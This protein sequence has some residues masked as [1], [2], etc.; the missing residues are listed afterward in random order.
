MISTEKSYIQPKLIAL[1]VDSIKQSLTLNT[2][3]NI[4]TPIDD[5]GHIYSTVSGIIKQFIVQKDE[6]NTI[7]DYVIIEND[8][9]NTV[10]P[11]I[12]KMTTKH[13]IE[14]YFSP[15]LSIEQLGSLH[16]TYLIVD[17]VFFDEPFATLDQ[18][19]IENSYD[20]IMT[21]L[22]SLHDIYVFK[23]VILLVKDDVS[24]RFLNSQ[25]FPIEVKSIKPEK[26]ID[27]RH[28]TINEIFKGT[29]RKTQTYNYLTFESILRL[30]EMITYNRPSV[31]NRVI[32]H[33]DAIKNPTVFQ[34]RIGTLFSDLKRIFNGYTTNKPLTILKNARL[35]MKAIDH[36][37]FSIT[38]TI[39]GLYIQE[40]RE[41]EIYDC[42]A[43][44]R[45]N[46]KCPAGI[47]PSKIM[48]AVEHDIYLGS[49]KTNLCIE[50]G[51]CT[52]YCPSK[53]PVMN[54][55]KKAKALLKGDD[56]V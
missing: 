3:V 33:G 47:L 38:K 2:P 53:I 48:H 14:S 44:G 20:T 43:C 40:H 25:S 31:L 6:H 23:T 54:F 42:I 49:M 24:S 30:K 22:K 5:T 35:E 8:T 39:I 10:D 32:V 34:V 46:N 15:S 51:L 29:L 17:L 9:K 27:F 52:Y 28:K 16:Q 4:G 26:G 36:D 19:F 56:D 7:K 11:R 13:L 21:T 37:Q 18:K 55:V 41:R 50:C 45:C 1:P 12:K